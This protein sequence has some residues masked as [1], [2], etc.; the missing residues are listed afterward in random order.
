MLLKKS[1]P[2]KTVYHLKMCSKTIFQNFDLVNLFS[3]V[4][5]DALC[6]ERCTT[7][8][9]KTL[10]LYP[11]IHKIN[12]NTVTRISFASFFVYTRNNKMFHSKLDPKF[13]GESEK[14]ALFSNF[15]IFFT[16]VG[17]K[18]ITFFFV[19]KFEE[20]YTKNCFPTSKTT[21]R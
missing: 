3:N 7:P 14:K 16:F 21:E 5:L 12:V 10:M 13:Y 15:L 1:T 11:S 18:K 2:P 19:K 4:S 8:N 9:N 6:L 20:K 17:T